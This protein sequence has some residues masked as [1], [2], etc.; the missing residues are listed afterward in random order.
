V[1]LRIVMS[2]RLFLACVG[3]AI[4]YFLAGKFGLAFFG[5]LHPSA[6]AVWPPTGVAIA[7]LL[8]FGTR[9][10]PAILIGAFA[11]N[12]TT[13]GSIWTSLGI[14]AG[15]T[16]EGVA[17]AYLVNRF[18]RG[19]DVFERAIDI[20]K[21]AG[22]AVLASTA[23]SAT[24]GVGSLAVGGYADP[25]Q[26]GPIWL[27]WW[28][29]D[30][31]GAIVV[32][33]LLVLWYRDHEVH[34]PWRRSLEAALLFSTVVGVTALFCF[35]PVLGDYP[36]V[37]LCTPPLVWA[38]FR[39]RQR[40]VATAVAIMSVITTFAT[41]TGN[42]P[43]VMAT[44]NE[45]LLVLQAFMAMIAM[46]ALVMAALVQERVA[47][48]RRERA[49]LGEAESSLRSS[50]AFLAMLSHELRNPLNAIAAAGAVLDLT[51]VSSDS[52]ARAAQIIRRQTAHL[53]RL[54]ED[55]LDVARITAGKIT[56]QRRRVDLSEVVEGAVQGLLSHTPQPP[57][58]ELEL[59]QT[60]VEADPD[61]LHQVVVN[62]VHNALKH[63][64]PNGSIRVKTCEQ[65]G[66]A[67]LR[68]EDSGAGIA[69]ELLPHVF[70]QFTQSKR[71]PNRSR[72]G[73]GIGLTLVRRLVELHGGAVHAHSGGP[74]LGST[75]AVRL[76]RA[77]DRANAEKRA[78]DSP[79]SSRAYR[80]LLVEDLADARD[81]LRLVLES[82]GHEVH[83]APDG[84]TA[85]DR[86]LE[87][88]PDIALV[89]L[90]LPGIDGHEVARRIRAAGMAARLVALTGYGRD[91]DQI[92][93]REAGFDAHLVKPVA[94]VRLQE[95][96]D[97]LLV[98]NRSAM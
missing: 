42:G 27:T 13:A 5:L 86:A 46:T 43:L 10:W 75:F 74:G 4:L 41:A 39:F 49:A 48:L 72:G 64:P 70:E 28:L 1:A 98:A 15:N 50:D 84:L 83:E 68:I 51:G 58:V 31:A 73:L 2:P 62:L 76:P 8:I 19:L 71:S 92:R 11:V 23:L 24:L 82:A 69:P 21:F 35:H 93:S 6:S 20:F 89:D 40:E 30:A 22:L 45:S 66:Y 59:G 16:L 7:A 61:R 33:P 53:T 79:L 81:A 18:A 57:P 63:T 44:P 78:P 14:A 47:L 60:W 65:D 91:E 56:L 26:L 87:L 3:I 97:G 32:T 9:V 34:A 88:K 95:V 94:M 55:L 17:A 90:G 25:T 12:F 38:A 96:M 54:I 36:L 80:I 77:A 37:F 67:V 29:G 85:V 52:S